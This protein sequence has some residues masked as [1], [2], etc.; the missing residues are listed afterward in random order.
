VNNT[1]E[2]AI[3]F[4]SKPLYRHFLKEYCKVGDDVSIEIVCKR[5]KR[6][7]SQNA[8]YHVYLSLIELSSG[9]TI[10]E[11]KRWVVETILSEGVSEIFGDMV[12]VTSSS[13]DL[14]ISE[15][16]EMMNKVEEKT[17]IPIPD[18]TPFSL[19]LTFD[20]YGKLKATQTKKYQNMQSKIKL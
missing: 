13:S 14:N 6:S 4:N 2:L 20:E 3:L 18:P 10:K 12:R 11:L 1:G 8:F 19:P 7:E 15:F 9:H 16:C 5:P 17:G